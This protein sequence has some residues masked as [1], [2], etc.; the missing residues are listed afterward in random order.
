MYVRL[1]DPQ[2]LPGESN[3]QRTERLA[4]AA[5]L[6]KTANYSGA[7]A[8]RIS[9]AGRVIRLIVMLIGGLFCLV[10]GL[11]GLVKPPVVHSEWFMTRIFGPYGVVT[12]IGLGLLLTSCAGYFLRK[13]LRDVRAGRYALPE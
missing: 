4:R 6:T 13:S 8:N 3:D 5:R 10:A 11:S 2:F 1:D 12:L 7:L 9:L